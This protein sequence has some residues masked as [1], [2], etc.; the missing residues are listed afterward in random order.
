[1][2]ARKNIQDYLEKVYP[3][4]SKES[5][6]PETPVHQ[7]AFL[8]FCYVQSLRPPSVDDFR[9]FVLKPI[10]RKP[11]LG[12][13]GFQIC[14]GSRMAKLPGLSDYEDTDLANLPDGAEL[15]PIMETGL[16]E[17]IEE[18]GMVLDN[19]KSVYHIGEVPLLSATTGQLSK[20]Y[21]YAAEVKNPL[22][23]EM[24][25]PLKSQVADRMWV[26]LE[27]MQE[28][29]RKDHTQVIKGTAEVLFQ[30]LFRKQ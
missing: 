20:V 12:D 15:E 19:L 18:L 17:A 16:R 13:P 29:G 22:D 28:I 30:F 2:T 8:P 1:M 4:A 24:P 27:E 7:V 11:E 23:F 3:N 14:K 5:I 10:N 9:F 26:T 6:S 21:L 25:D